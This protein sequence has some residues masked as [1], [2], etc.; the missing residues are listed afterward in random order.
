MS[1]EQII[2]DIFNAIETH[3]HDPI[4]ALHVLTKANGEPKACRIKYNN[5]QRGETTEVEALSLY[6]IGHLDQIKGSL[7]KNQLFTLVN[8]LTLAA[9]YCDQQN[10]SSA[11][12]GKNPLLVQAEAR[13]RINAAFTCL[14]MIGFD[15]QKLIS[16]EHS[17]V[18]KFL[19]LTKECG[20]NA[21]QIEIIAQFFLYYGKFLRYKTENCETAKPIE[22]LQYI[23]AAA[24]LSDTIK[25][26]V[27]FFTASSILYFI[28][29]DLKRYDDA[30]SLMKQS[31]ESAINL[32]R[33]FDASI[34]GC[35]AIAGLVAIYENTKKINF[36][37]EA[38]A[39]AVS[40]DTIVSEQ[41]PAVGENLFNTVPHYNAKIELLRI[42]LSEYGAEK[43]KT[44]ESALQL[45]KYAQ[46]I[47]TT[48]FSIYASDG[49]IKDAFSR[50]NIKTVQ[51]DTALK[52]F[53][54]YASLTDDMRFH[55]TIV[56]PSSDTKVPSLSKKTSKWEV[57]KKIVS[58]T[59]TKKGS[60]PT[61]AVWLELLD[62]KHHPWKTLNDAREEWVKS[63][64]RTSFFRFFAEKSDEAVIYSKI[65]GEKFA[66]TFKDGFAYKEHDLTLLAQ[67]NFTDLSLALF[68]TLSYKGK[69]DRPSTSGYAVFTLDAE[70]KKLFSVPYSA[71]QVHHT[72]CTD[73]SRVTSSGMIKVQK[74]KVVGVHLM[75]GHYKPSGRELFVILSYLH[76]QGVDISDRNMT[77]PFV[78]SE[79]LPVA[80]I[81]AMTTAIQQNNTAAFLE[82]LEY[83]PIADTIKQAEV[84]ENAFQSKEKLLMLHSATGLSLENFSVS[85]DSEINAAEIK[86]LKEKFS[87][88]YTDFVFGRS[89][90]QS[91]ESA[92]LTAIYYT[93]LDRFGTFVFNT[94]NNLKLDLREPILEAC[95]SQT[96]SMQEKLKSQTAVTFGM[97]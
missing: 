80:F 22:R 58:L 11:A 16:E 44:S 41:H 66:L 29:S 84:L 48:Y 46:D 82:N 27:L 93:V 90:P 75:S 36:L 94:K 39:L 3:L 12:L 50:T 20:F 95:V 23:N 69:P 68:D 37:L 54:K 15:I 2:R 6:I 59:S 71:D 40:L 87:T 45:L 83:Q 13:E 92:T 5:N 97:R 60:G 43:D 18:E 51:I 14:K 33:T 55:Q 63:E 62:P 65:F 79:F 74:G 49:K 57:V 72:S 81:Q 56:M 17:R 34:A 38:K 78:K 7:D 9:N 19:Y 88:L 32:N 91:Q 64:S 24:E 89:L 61:P 35:R 77:D 86:S 53:A 8:V 21:E 70:T 47:W 52:L 4:Q 73:G 96:L 1:R 67:N 25:H 31:Y 30:T 76:K 10:V 42:A 85:D 26:N 28:Y